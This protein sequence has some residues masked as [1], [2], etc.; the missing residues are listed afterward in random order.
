VNSTARR[1]RS[2]PGVGAEK[3]GKNH[4]PH[5]R[6]KEKLERRKVK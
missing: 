4:D 1:G 2:P 5:P 3:G 6:K